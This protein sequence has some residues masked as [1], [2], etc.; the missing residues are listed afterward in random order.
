MKIIKIRI[1]ATGILILFTIISGI[2]LSKLGRPLNV[3]IFA[4]HKI[5]ALLTTIL[6]VIIIYQLQKNIK[7]SNV[8]LIL[9][10]VTGLIFLIALISGALLSFEKPV[11]LILL[12]IHKLTPFL[13][14]VSTALTIYILETGR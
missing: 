3:V 8:E 12:T 7:L 10:A 6:T 14:V 13:I 2:W 1:I 4:I 9:I 5:I 11:N